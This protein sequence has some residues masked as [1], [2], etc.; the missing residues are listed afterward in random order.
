MTPQQFLELAKVLPEPCLLITGE[1]EVLAGN[2]PAAK[3]LELSLKELG[4]KIIF[5]IV[6]EDQKQVFKY[7]QA[8]SRSRSMV[9]G[10][11]S[12]RLEQEKTITCRWEGALIQPT[13]NQSSA[14]I[15][16]RLKNQ[17]LATEEFVLLNNKIDELAQEIHQKQKVQD[18]LSQSNK[19]LE[20][21]LE[22][23]QKTQ[24]QLIQAE[25]MSSLGQMVAG[26]AHEINNPV[27]FIHSNLDHLF[28]YV[29]AILDLLKLYQKFLPEPPE[30]IEEAIAALDLDFILEDLPKVLKSMEVGTNR[31]AE[32][33][34]NLR[35]FSRLDESDFKKVDVH[36]NI[37]SILMMLGGR[38]K[39]TT[40][41]LDVKVVKDYGKLPKIECY[42]AQLNQALMN[43]L[44][45]AIDALEN[46]EVTTKEASYI[47]SICIK[48]E[49]VDSDRI[50]ISINDNGCGISETIKNKL[51]D[52][53]FTTKAV[54]KGTGLGLAISYEIITDKHQGK[55]W[56]ESQ[57]GS[58][59][60]FTIELPVK[61]SSASPK[62]EPSSDR[63]PNGKV[64][65]HL[66]NLP[67]PVSHLQ[68]I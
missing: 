6:T 19:E 27:G 55:L 32:I 65:P 28:Q 16:L 3:M 64:Y 26:I 17:E 30:E 37:D 39:A 11:F 49:T 34:R 46:G 60:T 50:I 51:F 44:S 43:I 31:I 24:S 10:S 33:V 67:Q 41:R 15:F 68:Q 53:F 52:P 63:H 42:P 9:L 58:G 23:L 61:L 1:G 45:N 48:T 20:K 56:Y 40:K 4:G 29:E 5:D 7:L 13:S 66:E 36:E 21:A 14:L 38:F 12:F 22:K 62:K 25:K 57:P 54:G 59:T 2:K 8:C 35:I 18:S 47:P